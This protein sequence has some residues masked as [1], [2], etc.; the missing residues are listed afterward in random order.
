MLLV[1][2]KLLCDRSMFDAEKVKK[3]ES[4]VSVTVL[5]HH[6]RLLRRSSTQNTQNTHIHNHFVQTIR[7]SNLT[8]FY[9][10]HMRHK[11]ML[12]HTMFN[13]MFDV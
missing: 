6:R 7:T 4:T 3:I 8:V 13:T 11:I 5:Y 12:P 2:V 10:V 9:Q 1:I